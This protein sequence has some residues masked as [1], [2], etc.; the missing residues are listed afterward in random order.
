[1][2]ANAEPET[3]KSAIGKGAWTK[4]RLEQAL[5]QGLEDT[6]PASDPVAVSE[7]ARTP[8]GDDEGPRAG[9]EAD[10]ELQS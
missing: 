4:E 10:E 2:F 3:P 6:F 7:P 8:P 9:A 5:E 1:M